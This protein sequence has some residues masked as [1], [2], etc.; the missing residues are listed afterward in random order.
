MRVRTCA[1][2][3]GRTSHGDLCGVFSNHSVDIFHCTLGMSC[4]REDGVVVLGGDVQP[5]RDV[6]IAVTVGRALGCSE[7]G[8]SRT[9]TNTKR[10]GSLFVSANFS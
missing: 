4:S 5:G 10:G 8:W 2:Y 7:F 1:P 3:S 6:G 9:H